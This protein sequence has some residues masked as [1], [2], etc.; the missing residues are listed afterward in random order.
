MWIVAGAFRVG[1]GADEVVASAG[2]L[3]TFDTG[4][5]AGATGATGLAD[6]NEALLLTFEKGLT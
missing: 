1:H 3:V 2:R 5:P 6:R 4:G